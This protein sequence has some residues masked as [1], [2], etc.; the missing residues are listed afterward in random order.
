ML[1]SVV[2]F[3]EVYSVEPSIPIVIEFV[4]VSDVIVKDENVNI[5]YLMWEYIPEVVGNF[6]TIISLQYTSII[7]HITIVYP[8][9]KDSSDSAEFT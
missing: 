3:F 2:N 9:V 4:Y 8:Q 7:L 1:Q 6:Y 5:V